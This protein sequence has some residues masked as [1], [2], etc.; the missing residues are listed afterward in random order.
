[1]LY[2]TTIL[3]LLYYIISYHIVAPTPG[4]GTGAATTPTTTNNNNNH[5]NNNH[6][7]IHSRI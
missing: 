4:V 1:M 2:Y 6:K 5:N 3:C 7:N